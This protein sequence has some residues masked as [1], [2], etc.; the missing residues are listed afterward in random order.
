[1]LA[2]VFRKFLTG[3]SFDADGNLD[4]VWCEPSANTAAWSNYAKAAP[5]IRKLRALVAASSAVG[6]FRLDSPEEAL[7]LLDRIR[8]VKSVDPALAVYAAY[9]FNDRRMRSHIV[10]MQRYLDSTLGVRIFDLA[11]LAFAP[12]AVKDRSAMEMYPC[13]PMLTQGWALLSPL[14]VK[15]PRGLDKLRG[16]LRPSLWTHFRP[17]AAGMLRSALKEEKV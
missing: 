5:E 15:L 12:A 11:I 6:V 17:D 10:D 7:T 1:M 9:A 3:L 8:N 2:P 13:V 14:G 16:E 4:D